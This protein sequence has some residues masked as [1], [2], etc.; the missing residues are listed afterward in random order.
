MEKC[1]EII[2][3]P[4]H[5]IFKPLNKIFLK[6]NNFYFIVPEKNLAIRLNYTLFHV[7]S[8]TDTF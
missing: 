3:C 2:T 4:N 7:K 5:A 1:F 8:K 6:I